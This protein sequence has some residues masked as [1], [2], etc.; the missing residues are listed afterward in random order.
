MFPYSCDARLFHLP[1][2]TG[3]LIVFNLLVFVSADA[4]RIDPSQGWLLEYGTGL[5]PLQWILSPFMHAGWGHLLG[6]MFFLWTFGLVVEG[7]LG[8]WKFLAA[9]LGIAVGQS[10]LEQAIMPHFAPDVEGTL[11]ASAAI[12]GLMAMACVWAPAN[13]LSIFMLILLRPVTFE[14]AVGYFAAF[15]AAM[16]ILFSALLGT[17][18]VGSIAHLMGGAMGLCVGLALL[19]RGVVDCEDW[20]LPSVLSGTYGAEKKK[21]REEQGVDPQQAATHSQQQILE[22]R[23][24]FDAYLEID[25]PEQALQVKQRAAHMSRP[26]DLERKDL[27][28]LITGLQK[29]GKWAVSAPLMAELI[30][31]FPAESQQVRLKLAQICLVEL[32]R[33]NRALDLLAPF[34]TEILPPEQERLRQKMIAAAQRKIDEGALEVDDGV[35]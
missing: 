32:D 9:Y 11:G 15:Y 18:A 30:E 20:D 24:K 35:W 23:R 3:A 1:I 19:K 16:D 2:V 28:R 13:E 6:N 33:P 5:H 29:H 8:W 17:G 25:Q 21:K 27:M 14:I 7:K 26:L 31:V 34:E 12:Y 10:A 22:A 4:G